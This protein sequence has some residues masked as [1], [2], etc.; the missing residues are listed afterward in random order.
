[1][2]TSNSLRTI[3]CRPQHNPLETLVTTRRIFKMG[4]KKILS[5]LPVLVACLLVLSPSRAASQRLFLDGGASIAE[6]NAGVTTDLQGNKPVV[7]GGIM[8]EASDVTRFSLGARTRG[9]LVAIEGGVEL[10]PWKHTNRISPYLSTGFGRYVNGDAEKGTIP[11]GLGLDYGVTS[12]LSI[13]AEVQAR[14]ALDADENRG[15]PTQTVISGVTPTLG[16][17]YKLETIE[18][19]P[20]GQT[21]VEDDDASGEGFSDQREKDRWRMRKVGEK[22]GSLTRASSQ[23]EIPAMSIHPFKI[24]PSLPSRAEAPESLNSRTA[25]TRSSKP[26]P[27]SFGRESRLRMRTRE[28]RRFPERSPCQR[29]ATWSAFRTVPSSWG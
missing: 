20:P 24:R 7:A 13:N 21:P 2:S 27:S 25:A 14:W 19:R 9:S 1:M 3:C 11:V 18:R 5:L 8:I 29:T 6:T 17:S 10:H 26:L 23:A 4:T 28:S 15:V 22:E 12:N 16:V